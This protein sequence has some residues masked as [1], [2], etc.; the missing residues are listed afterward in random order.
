MADLF[1]S[2]A[3]EDVQTAKMVAGALQRSG[4]SVWYSK[5][6][7]GSTEDEL[8]AAKA[9]I[10]L[11]S[12]FSATDRYVIGEVQDAFQKNTLFPVLL[13]DVFLS[14]P[15]DDL[16]TANLI[17]WKGDRNHVE[18]KSLVEK[19]SSIA[20]PKQRA[21]NQDFEPI[22]PADA[23]IT[24]SEEES[25]KPLPPPESSTEETSEVGLIPSHT[26]NQKTKESPVF[27]P[28]SLKVNGESIFK[29]KYLIYA[30]L[31]ALVLIV[32]WK[33]IGNQS[34]SN[35]NT[36]NDPVVFY[37]PEK[38]SNAE[39]PKKV[40]MTAKTITPDLTNASSSNEVAPAFESEPQLT[41]E[42][43]ENIKEDTT[44][45]S[46]PKV[47]YPPV[48]KEDVTPT[49]ESSLSTDNESATSEALEL[50]E[51]GDSLASQTENENPLVKSVSFY[52]T[53]GIGAEA[54]SDFSVG[55]KVFIGAKV[56]PTGNENFRFEWS[57][58]DGQVLAEKRISTGKNT[59]GLNIYDSRQEFPGSG[60]FKVRLYG[61]DNQ[62]LAETVF[63]VN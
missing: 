30:G 13:E 59:N 20:T 51:S 35:E 16:E 31:A 37:Y 36:S 3:S 17:D 4:W 45:T 40:G 41:E 33:I 23:P 49:V 46:R 25:T 42:P 15:F 54:R 48:Q 38:P 44:E 60:Q 53:S 6:P 28:A 58:S 26:Q 22:E 34:D 9:V 57:T 32:G 19:I 47:Y 29:R 61:G 11:W 63:T 2:H 18:F 56:Y 7:H 43:I 14:A 1:I 55:E 10:V 52:T 21:S 50:E 8:S 39:E 27:W 62:L 24:S 12:Q 5:E